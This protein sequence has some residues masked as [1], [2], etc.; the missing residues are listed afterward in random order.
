MP[1]VIAALRRIFER[2]AIKNGRANSPRRNGRTISIMKPM[3]EASLS[4]P[5]FTFS[6]PAS[7]LPQRHVRHR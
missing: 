4:G 3:P 7:R 5:N 2:S 6:M 1:E